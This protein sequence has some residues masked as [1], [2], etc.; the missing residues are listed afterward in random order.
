MEIHP[1]TLVTNE[2]TM[3]DL[4]LGGLKIIQPRQGY[5][6]S[7]D[8]IL[9]AHF[10]DLQGRPR[11]F[12][13]G[14]GNGVIAL[15]LAQRHPEAQIVGV[16]IQEQMAARAR[17]SVVL[18]RLQEQITIYHTDLREIAV[19]WEAE[20]ADLVVSNPPFWKVGQGK[21]SQDPEQAVARHELMVTLSQIIAA[22]KYL[23]KP[24]GRLALILPAY[25]L[26]ETL[27]E[28]RQQG[29]APYRLRMVHPLINR[30]AG[31]F[32]L[33]ALRGRSVDLKILPPLIIYEHPGVYGEELTRLYRLPRRE[34]Q[35]I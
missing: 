22:G 10:P 14:T 11:V 23:L 17:R 3:D 13:L 28:I 8:S 27:E 30:D 26:G 1:D 33:E 5:R 20:Q 29:L 2:E 4:I 32:M 21:I 18:N 16:D 24:G 35:G 25:R 34:E 15:L 12:D 9:L 31:H 6:F 19:G 7:I